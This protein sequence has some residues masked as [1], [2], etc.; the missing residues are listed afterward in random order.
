MDEY[1]LLQLRTGGIFNIY[2]LVL[3]QIST[4]LD[5]AIMTALNDTRLLEKSLQNYDKTCGMAYHCQN[6]PNHCFV[7]QTRSNM[8][9]YFIFSPTKAYFT[10]CFAIG[11]LLF[12]PQIS[13][14][15]HPSAPSTLILTQDVSFGNGRKPQVFICRYINTRLQYE[16]KFPSNVVLD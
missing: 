16:A 7:P 12:D 4:R 5:P 9:W 15:T 2:G 6:T 10:C 14:P 1:Q 3:C 13:S 8:L 11:S